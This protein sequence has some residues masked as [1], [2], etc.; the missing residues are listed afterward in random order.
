M[1]SMHSIPGLL[2]DLVVLG[3][4][5]YLSLLVSGKIRMRADRQKKWDAM[6]LRWGMPLRIAIYL[7]TLLVIFLIL[8]TIFG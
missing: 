5:I 7:V 8:R 1:V 2:D 3:I 6:M 4:F